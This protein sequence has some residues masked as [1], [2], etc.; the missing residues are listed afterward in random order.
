MCNF[1]S[2]SFIQNDA[3][4]FD[5]NGANFSM[6]WQKDEVVEWNASD[7]KFSGERPGV[8]RGA[9]G[10]E[11]GRGGFGFHGRQSI[12]GKEEIREEALITTMK[13]DK[14]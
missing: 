4:T 3:S 11:G 8:S 14:K 7:K 5:E 12:L 1:K 6:W 13:L 10:G 2:D 9:E